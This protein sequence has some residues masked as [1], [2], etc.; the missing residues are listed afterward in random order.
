MG[1]DGHRLARLPGQP[2]LGTH[3]LTHSLTHSPHGGDD[4]MLFGP[5]DADVDFVFW[6]GLVVIC[7][8]FCVLKV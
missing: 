3:S 6:V 7:R 4:L 2:Q 8:P 5:V 1:A